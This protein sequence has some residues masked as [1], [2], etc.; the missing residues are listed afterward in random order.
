MMIICCII[1][2]IAGIVAGIAVGAVQLGKKPE[3]AAD[4]AKK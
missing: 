2:C 1:V 3:E 4:A